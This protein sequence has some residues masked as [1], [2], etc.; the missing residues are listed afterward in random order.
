MIKRFLVGY[1]GS[2][3]SREAFAYSLMFAQALRAEVRIIHVI[4]SDIQT[5]LAGDP[6]V[7]MDPMMP[8]IMLKGADDATLRKQVADSEQM[9]DELEDSCLSADVAY[10]ERIHHGGLI[11]TLFGEVRDGDVIA[12][13]L[14]GRFR[15]TG[16]GSSTRSL[17]SRSP[18][19]VLVVSGPLVPINRVLTPY[20]GMAPST[21]A[22][23]FAR[24]LA[25]QTGWPLSVLA[26]SRGDMSQEEAC[27]WA[28]QLAPAAQVM[29][30]NSALGSEAELIERVVG[31]DP[32]AL[33]VMGAYSDS[34]LKDLFAGSTTSHVLSHLKAPIILVQKQTP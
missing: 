32:Y 5:V 33:L 24:D 18:C 20:D 26:M 3:L 19:P 30:Q 14:K 8:P 31:A 1:D 10:S 16:V 13:G 4:E 9:L 12:L 27:D 6:S 7:M 2:D 28:R 34:W 23:L 15:R 22:L 17:V 29:A 11:D 25:T 21:R